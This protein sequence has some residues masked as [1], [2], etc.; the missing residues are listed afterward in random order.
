MNG[1][2]EGLGLTAEQTAAAYIFLSCTLH[3]ALS[4]SQ[5]FPSVLSFL[6]GIQSS[7]KE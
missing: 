7:W 1:K 6:R 2:K 4:L 3:P 5:S